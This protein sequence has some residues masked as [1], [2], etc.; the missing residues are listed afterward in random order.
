ML[1]LAA[2]SANL[3]NS[4]HAA[5]GRLSNRD[6][7]LTYAEPAHVYVSMPRVSILS[8]YNTSTYYSLL[9]TPYVSIPT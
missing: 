2:L 9:S 1:E 8:G 6:I 7:P 3:V 4:A 5:F